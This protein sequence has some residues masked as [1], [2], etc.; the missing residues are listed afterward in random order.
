MGWKGCEGE[1][2][3]EGVIYGSERGISRNK[4]L[5]N[6]EF[7]GKSLLVEERYCENTSLMRDKPDGDAGDSPE[8]QG[9]L[10]Q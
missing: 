2:A 9:T 8:N 1:G 5:Q 3:R 7:W 10:L 4:N 6:W